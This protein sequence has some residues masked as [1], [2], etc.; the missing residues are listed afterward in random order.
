MGARTFARQGM[1][2]RHTRQQQEFIVRKL[3]ALE[4]PREIVRNFM[5]VFTDTKCDENDVRRLDPSNVA[6]PFDL[7][8]IF[9]AERERIRNDPNSAPFA[10][11]KLRLVALSRDVEAYR[12]NNQ[13][14][15]ARSVMR[16]IAEE[17]GA[18]GG[19]G[20]AAKGGTVAAPSDGKPVAEIVRKIIDPKAPEPA[21]EPVE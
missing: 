21:A 1:A 7:F 17:Q 5:A 14:A 9:S 3:A 6:L 18:I 16:Q 2:N 11:K 4:P 8:T 12:S 20:A 15:E 19:K 13:P 10:D